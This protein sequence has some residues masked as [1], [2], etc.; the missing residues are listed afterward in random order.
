MDPQRWQQIEQ[1][2]HLALE[3]ETGERRG[4]LIDACQGDAELRRQ[5]ESLLE[6]SGS[7]GALVDRTAWAAVRDLASTQTILKAHEMLGP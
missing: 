1:L 2:Y 3:R 6:Q 7:T 4:F 5:V